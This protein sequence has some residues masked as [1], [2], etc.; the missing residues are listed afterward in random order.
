[1]SPQRLV[2]KRLGPQRGTVRYYGPLGDRAIRGHALEG[3]T[4]PLSLSV[5]Y[6]CFEAHEVSHVCHALLMM[7]HPVKGPKL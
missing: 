5:S 3:D 6:Y 7:C 1:M 2:Y 4:G